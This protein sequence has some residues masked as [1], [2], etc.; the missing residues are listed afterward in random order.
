MNSIFPKEKAK[1][2]ATTMGAFIS[3]KKWQEG[4][5]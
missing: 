2:E 5:L 4:I 3:V 1:N